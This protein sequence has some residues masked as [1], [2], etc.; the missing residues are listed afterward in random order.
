LKSWWLQDWLKTTQASRCFN[1]K[2]KHCRIL[3]WQL[4]QNSIRGSTCLLYNHLLFVVPSTFI[5]LL[6]P[7]RRYLYSYF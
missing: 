6:V 2:M 5:L 4:V 7:L 1:K 3:Q